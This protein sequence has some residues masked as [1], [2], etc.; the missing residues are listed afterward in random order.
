M[1]PILNFAG[2]VLATLFA[3]GVA[4]ACNWVML[5]VTFHL[6]QPAAVSKATRQTLR[7]HGTLQL[8]RAFTPNR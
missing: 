7:A 1:I 4:V 8:A 5:Q 3:A 6:M 2:L